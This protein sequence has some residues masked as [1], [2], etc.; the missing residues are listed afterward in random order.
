M[1]Q[2]ILL[3]QTINLNLTGVAGLAVSSSQIFVTDSTST[4]AKVEQCPLSGCPGTPPTA[5][6][7][8]SITGNAYFARIFYD[9]S[10][11]ALYFGSSNLGEAYAIAPSGT[12][13]FQVSDGAPYG[14]ATDS[15]HLFMADSN[16]IS[17]V[18]K[19]SGGTPTAL[20]ATLGYTK[21]VTIDGAGT[22]WAAAANNGWVASCPSSLTGCTTWGWAP[23]VPSDIQISGG[24]PFIAD[25][26]K[27]LLKCASAT[28]CSP[29]NATLVYATGTSS[30]TADATYVYFPGSN[31]T[32]LQCAAAGCTTPTV[33]AASGGPAVIAMTNDA[34]WVY[35]LTSTGLI[36]KVAK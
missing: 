28:D 16:G 8:Y 13:L 29:G 35:W 25:P 32:I 34:T 23:D 19:S 3:G 9:A 17:Y 18:N 27:G 5:T 14:F 7:I 22:I 1:C 36:L 6:S 4:V 24:V 15:T 20:L 30:F 33:I 31:N 12:L 21:A 2:A 11:G 26:D 10:V